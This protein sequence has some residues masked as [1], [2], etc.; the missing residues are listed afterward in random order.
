MMS[1]PSSSPFKEVLPH[2]IEPIEQTK[3][4]NNIYMF[5]EDYWKI[6]YEMLRRAV[7][8]MAPADQVITMELHRANQHAGQVRR[9]AEARIKAEARHKIESHHR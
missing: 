3:D 7:S 2:E 1:V 6:P 5:P 9:K 8:K 4:T